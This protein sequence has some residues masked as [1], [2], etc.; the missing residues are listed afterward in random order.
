M[1][2]GKGKYRQQQQYKFKK[3]QPKQPQQP[4]PIPPRPNSGQ[5]KKADPSPATMARE[6]TGLCFY[7]WSFGEKAHT[8]QA[9]C[10][11]QGN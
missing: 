11:W 4:P 9:P 6:S 8:C 1:V 3:Q 10:A 7:H 5:Q 2:R